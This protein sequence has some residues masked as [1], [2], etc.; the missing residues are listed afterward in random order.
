MKI[1]IAE[2]DRNNAAYLRKGLRECGYAVDLAENGA[3]AL[4]LA[5]TGDY[6]VIVLDVMLPQRDGWSILAT[7]RSLGQR[8]PVMF[9]TA[10]DAVSDRVKGLELGADDY[11]VK[12]FMF[13]ELLARVRAVLRRGPGRQ[14][15][16]LSIADLKVDLLQQKVSRGAGRIELTNKEYRLLALLA[17]RAGETLS[18][19]Q[20]AE[21]V[22]DMNFDSNTNVVDVSI[23]RLRSKIDDPFD[24]KLIHCARGRGYVL[25]AR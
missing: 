24:T 9:L 21:Q 2:D 1:L 11:L 7:L 23:R 10:C 8:T 6:D 18:R 12:P 20:I 14:L 17:R 15:E 3:D 22:W 16:T 4:F 19:T 5:S 25:E 13:S